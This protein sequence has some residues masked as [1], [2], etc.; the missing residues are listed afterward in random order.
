MAN[1]TIEFEFLNRSIE[2]DVEYT[3]SGNYIAATHF[4]PAEYPE[5]ELER[6]TRIIKGQ[7]VE[8]NEMLTDE[9]FELITEITQEYLDEEVREY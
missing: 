5:L 6:I 7:P 4:E 1:I 9:D 2:V 8:L 3:I